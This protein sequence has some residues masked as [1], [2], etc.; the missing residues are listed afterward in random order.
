MRRTFFHVTLWTFITSLLIFALFYWGIPYGLVRLN[1]PWCWN[2]LTFLTPSLRL[3][4]SVFWA[5]LHFVLAGIRNSR[6]GSFL[7]FVKNVIV[8]SVI[9]ALCYAFY[10]GDV[11]F[12]QL[13]DIDFSVPDISQIQEYFGSYISS[14][15]DSSS[16]ASSASGVVEIGEGVDPSLSSLVES[17]PSWLLSYA[18]T[19]HILNESDFAAAMA[20]HNIVSNGMVAG[21]SAYTYTDNG[22]TLTSNNDEE[23]YLRASILDEETVLHEL[24]HCFDFEHDITQKN[25]NHESSDLVYSLYAQNPSL[26]SAYGATSPSEYFAEA[27]ALY[28]TD[29]A[30]LYSL[31]PELYSLFSQLFP[32]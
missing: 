22:V 8:L 12:S 10:T 29:S 14:S 1:Q 24:V 6:L 23:V 28:L 11:G 21:F 17:A 5:V 25:Q 4:I 16:S 3:W 19:I 9:A 30:R 15:S 2:L 7:R 26:I 13:R 32:E 20:D 31:S 27:G 18:R